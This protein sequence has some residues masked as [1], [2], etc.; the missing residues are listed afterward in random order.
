MD[1]TRNELQHMTST[2]IPAD[3]RAGMQAKLVE[4]EVQW[5]KLQ[6]ECEGRNMRLITIHELLHNYEKA[7]APFMVSETNCF[8]YIVQL[9]LTIS[10]S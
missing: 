5:A 3:Q 4:L 8:F 10:D 1:V 7:V 2:E 9:D 6:W